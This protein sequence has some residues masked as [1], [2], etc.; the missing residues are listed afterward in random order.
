MRRPFQRFDRAV[1]GNMSILECL[2]LVLRH[3]VIAHRRR[4]CANDRDFAELTRRMIACLDCREYWR[5]LGAII[6]QDNQ[7]FVVHSA[8]EEIP[9]HSVN[10]ARRGSE[11]EVK[12]IDEV[13]AVGEGDTGILPRTLEAAE[14]RAQHPELPELALHD[15]IAQPKRRRIEP[16]NVSYLQDQFRFLREPR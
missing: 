13:N 8:I 10:A 5:A 3:I 14:S 1:A 7:R 15:R 11:K 6:F 16:K 12:E 2:D 9:K 4:V